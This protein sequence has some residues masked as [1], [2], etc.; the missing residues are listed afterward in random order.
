MKKTIAG[1][2]F[3]LLAALPLAAQQTV[4]TAT[5]KDPNAI[6]YAN[7]TVQASLQ[8]SGGPA[9]V[10]IANQ[11]QCSAASAGTAPCKI[12]ISGNV[13]PV[14]IDSTGTF[15]MTLYSNTSITPAASHWLFTINISPGIPL[16]LG[17]GPQT[18]SVAVTVTGATQNISATL[19]AAAP[20]LT[21]FV[22]GGGFPVACPSVI[23][24]Q[25]LFDNAGD[26]G[27][28]AGSAVTNATGATTLTAT[29]DAVVPLGILGHSVTQSVPAFT[30]SADGT[31]VSC[32]VVQ[33]FIATYCQ[34]G[35]ETVDPWHV[36][37][38]GPDHDTGPESGNGITLYMN[39]TG[40]PQAEFSVLDKLGSGT[41]S[42]PDGGTAL[43]NFYGIDND[44][45]DLWDDGSSTIYA[46]NA[47]GDCW[48]YWATAP[49]SASNQYAGGF[50][51]C[52]GTL[53][54][55]IVAGTTI[56]G[57]VQTGIA[58][59]VALVDGALAHRVHVTNPGTLAADYNFA[60]PITPGAVGTVLT[61][62]GGGTTPMTW[63]SFTAFSS[64]TSCGTTAACGN[65]AVTAPR[66]VTGTVTTAGGAPTVTVTG[67]SPAFASA[68]SYV[69][70]ITI[71][72]TNTGGVAQGVTN[73]SGSSFTLYSTIAGPVNYICIGN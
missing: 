56:H 26:C 70:T 36:Q 73:V 32:P 53:W 22:S 5:I 31:A 63:S 37:Y 62:Q 69:C 38:Y 19:T 7:G 23:S 17:T 28:I 35:D 18:F 47:F 24:P 41:D 54:A 1:I 72:D 25:I 45:I 20:A 29:G 14:S 66:V 51:P 9:T 49:P 6:P 43:T 12:P 39:L 11:A 34:Y 15:V 27:S 16:P 2:V 46:N 13:G 48:A 60:L 52:T 44:A 71:D 59:S 4:V 10:T 40:A 64:V 58:G 61:S 50:D 42:P 55:G 68:A 67:I 8:I 65:T 33:S 30:V 21:N 3:L 57:T